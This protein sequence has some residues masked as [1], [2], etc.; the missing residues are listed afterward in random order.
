MLA[1]WSRATSPSGKPGNEFDVGGATGSSVPTPRAGESKSQFVGRCFAWPDLR[2]KKPRQRLGECYGLW[3]EHRPH[4]HDQKSC[5][6]SCSCNTCKSDAYSLIYKAGENYAQVSLNAL[7]FVTNDEE[8][9]AMGVLSSS[10]RD[11]QGDII[12]ATGVDLEDHKINP[13]VLYD[14]GKAYALPIGVTESPDG[15]YCVWIDPEAE[16]IT[17]KTYFAPTKFAQQVYQLVRLRYLR[18]NSIAIKDWVVRP[19]PPDPE[20]GWPK[21]P[22]G[23]PPYKHILRSSLAEVTW[24]PLPANPDAVASLL[25]K[26]RLDGNEV[27]DPLLYKSLLPFVPAKRVWERGGF[28]YKAWAPEVELTSKSL[29]ASPSGNGAPLPEKSIM[30]DSTTGADGAVDAPAGG[31]ETES[32]APPK[33]GSQA[34]R[35]THEMLGACKDMLQHHMGMTENPKVLEHLKALDDHMTAHMGATADTHKSE[36]PDE[37]PLEDKSGTGGDDLPKDAPTEEVVTNKTATKP[38]AKPTTTKKSYEDVGREALLR[39]LA[40]EKAE[41]DAILA[42]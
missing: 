34:L 5:G 12:E 33:A 2:S 17:Q 39:T 7:D 13:V 16:I 35:D 40:R 23:A 28:T 4:S 6:A 22:D 42:S 38:A 27:I 29:T 20:R 14:H 18:A 21:R 30:A 1:G 26:G 10:N 31:L 8:T 19:L 15:E 3:R 24:T 41:L 36:Y 25:G 11:R 9:S 32:S 37:D